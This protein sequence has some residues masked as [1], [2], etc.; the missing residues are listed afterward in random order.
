LSDCSKTLEDDTDM[1]ACVKFLTFWE[2]VGKKQTFSILNNLNHHFAV[3][4]M[5]LTVSGIAD[6]VEPKFFGGLSTN[7]IKTHPRP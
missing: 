4:I 5:Y 2:P 1:I 6:L 3:P 7:K